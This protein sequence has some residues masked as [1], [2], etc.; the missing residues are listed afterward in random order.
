MKTL[1]TCFQNMQAYNF[2]FFFSEGNANWIYNNVRVLLNVII[3]E[4]RGDHSVGRILAAYT[5][6]PELRSPTPT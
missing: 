5:W 3:Q 1:G 4:D 6:T 2:V